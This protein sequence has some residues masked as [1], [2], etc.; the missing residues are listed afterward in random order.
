MSVAQIGL[1]IAGCKGGYRL[2]CSNGIVDAQNDEV[3]RTLS[4]IRS[5]IRF[6]RNHLTLYALE[7]TSKH[8]VYSVYRSCNDNGSGAFVN[9]VVY[10]PHRIRIPKVR[11]MLD[12]M[13]EY[14]FKEYVNPIHGT[15]YPGT[16]DN[17]APFVDI[18]KGAGQEEERAFYTHLRST[19]N[20]IPH[21]YIYND[22][23]EVDNFFDSPCRKEFFECQEVM[24]MAR[25][26]F[27]KGDDWFTFNKK[28]EIITHVSEPE[29]MPVLSLDVP[30]VIS[31]KINGVECD[32]KSS[33]PVNIST[34]EVEIVLKYKYCREAVVKGLISAILDKKELKLL[35]VEKQ[36]VL[37]DIVKKY[38]KY[39]VQFSINGQKSPDGVIQL[40]SDDGKSQDV[41][42]S[43]TFITGNYLERE[44]D[45][46]I[47][48]LMGSQNPLLCVG[49]FRPLD[50]ANKLFDIKLQNFT[51]Y[52]DMAGSVKDCIFVNIAGIK[53]IN[54]GVLRNNSKVS[55]YLPLDASI[56]TIEFDAE[57]PEVESS[58][59]KTLK[60][61]MLKSKVLEYGIKFPENI[62]SLI[63][64]WDFTIDG[65]SR[66]KKKLNQEEIIKIDT[67]EN[68][69]SGV[70][71]IN[72]R[73]YSFELSEYCVVPQMVYVEAADHVQYT[74]DAYGID[75]RKVSID[76]EGTAVF[77]YGVECRITVAKS[78]S[79]YTS[80]KI[81]EVDGTL[82][83]ELR[84]E[85]G[86]AKKIFTVRFE[87]CEGLYYAEA[88][89]KPRTQ[90]KDHL[91]IKELKANEDTLRLYD[92]EQA[93]KGKTLC[94][95]NARKDRLDFSAEVKNISMDKSG[96]DAYKVEY[97]R[98]DLPIFSIILA[99]LV[100]TII[101]VGAILAV[102]YW[103]SKPSRDTVVMTIEVQVAE[104]PDLGESIEILTIPVKGKIASVRNN[105][106]EVYWN[107]RGYSDLSAVT[108]ELG[109]YEMTQP[110]TSEIIKELASI[111][112]ESL[113]SD[114]FKS[115]SS[116][117]VIKTKLQNEFA[118][119]EKSGNWQ[120]FLKAF[121]KGKDDVAI[122][123]ILAAAAPTGKDKAKFAEY[124][125]RFKDFADYEPYKLVQEKSKELAVELQAEEYNIQLCNKAADYKGQLQGDKCTKDIVDK[126]ETWW[127]GLNS[128]DKEKIRKAQTSGKWFFD[129]AVIAYPAFFAA[130]N[131]AEIESLKGND[132]LMSVFSENQKKLIY[133]Y[134]TNYTTMSRKGMTFIADKES[135]SEYVKFLNL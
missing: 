63:L 10:V 109:N 70:L 132:D 128:S 121:K 60:M 87:G 135:T 22:V 18:L 133:K 73:P 83:Y 124:L 64:S 8:K 50:Y 92:K 33:Y 79:G 103:N 52:V 89:G 97:T 34:D 129:H 61:L 37:G 1:V 111:D 106:I 120:D 21:F 119:C 57:S 102:N 90:I 117:L 9:I 3:S 47:Q 67:N 35:P 62:K 27:E 40:R 110:L 38:E 51:F 123:T 31:L 105:K 72:G 30:E 23:S 134:A 26:M 93:G 16:Y 17:I 125:D 118:D 32:K 71:M 5:V 77:P 82:F 43:Q 130:K 115:K 84:K 85:Q 76:G 113:N 54:L 7:F 69:R 94:V 91:F 19:Q 99:I 66:K 11:E 68:V 41:L 59:D 13:I 42:D 131:K 100:G 112:E 25:N 81:K 53:P 55:L 28:P 58:F 12:R 29:C 96:N 44:W 46:Y 98:S 24:F 39:L 78:A 75:G 36:I 2:L 114:A 126:F 14:Y 116:T 74:Y 6:N 65:V 127:N 108:V 20:D 56:D 15:Y 49:K 80:N 88:T 107:P 104:E 4:D 122:N 48:P 101:G 86:K 45:I 95:I